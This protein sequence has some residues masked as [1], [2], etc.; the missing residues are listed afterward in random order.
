MRKLKP[1][2]PILSEPEYEYVCVC[3]SE[4]KTPICNP[5]CLAL[6]SKCLCHSVGE[7]KVGTEQRRGQMTP[8]PSEPLALTP[9]TPSGRLLC[10]Q[11]LEGN[12]QPAAGPCLAWRPS[13]TDGKPSYP[14]ALVTQGP[15]T[16]PM[17]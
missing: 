10:L 15:W 1:L 13:P 16:Q 12:K 11:A 2:G 7:P 4:A 5:L 9:G 14:S 6:M 3:V 17:C 8:T